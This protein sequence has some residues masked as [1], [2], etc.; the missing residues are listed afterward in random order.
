MWFVRFSRIKVKIRGLNRSAASISW[1]MSLFI[2]N[3]GV[4]LI[5]RQPNYITL[6]FFYNLSCSLQI[7]HLHQKAP[8]KTLS[9]AALF[10]LY[11]PRNEFH[12]QPAT[13]SQATL[14]W[15]A[16]AHDFKFLHIH[17]VSLVVQTGKSLPA[18][19]QYS[20]LG[21]TTDRRAWWAKVHGD[22]KSWTGQSD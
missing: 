20:C 22:P 17:W 10:F 8:S 19:F 6:L 9:F 2:L 11:M 16:W 12:W 4:G 21:K 1:H 14:T 13:A 5:K 7:A 18:L 3:V 15:S